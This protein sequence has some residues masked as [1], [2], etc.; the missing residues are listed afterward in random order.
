M[1]Q[2]SATTACKEKRKWYIRIPAVH[3]I[4]NILYCMN[5]SCSIEY[6]DKYY[7]QT[8]RLYHPPGQHVALWTH[9]VAC[10]KK[11]KTPEE[12]RAGTWIPVHS[13]RPTRFLKV[14]PG[15]KK[16][17]E[18]ENQSGVCVSL[19]FSQVSAGRVFNPVCSALCC[20]AE[21][22]TSQ[23]A[24]VLIHPHQTTSWYL[25]AASTR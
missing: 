14:M 11:K 17:Q 18:R 12:V 23:T 15:G 20:Q 8:A 22:R 1:G 10:Q 16:V 2:M 4:Y 24:C 13:L 9:N 21:R 7:T 19:G 3:R 6:L 5:C 25:S